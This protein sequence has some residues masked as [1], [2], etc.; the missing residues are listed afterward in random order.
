MAFSGTVSETIFTTRKVIET[1]ARR[2]KVPSAQLT[3]ESVQ[4]AS[5]LLYL[6]ISSYANDG[7]PLW[8]IEKQLY[9]LYEGVARIVMDRGTVDVLNGNTRRIQKLA[10]VPFPSPEVY[11]MDFGTFTTVTTAGLKWLGPAVPVTFERSDTGNDWDWQEAL[12]VTPVAGEGEWTWFDM[13]TF[14]AFNRFR[15]RSTDGTTP[16]PLDRVVFGNTPTEIPLA[17]M[18]KDDYTSLPNKAFKSDQPLQYWFDRQIK[19]PV[20]HLWPVPNAASEEKQV[21]VWRQRHIMDVGAM[22]QE[23]EFPQRW[24]EAVVAGLAAKLVVELPEADLGRKEMLDM[25]ASKTLIA[26]RTEERDNSPIYM[27]PNISPYTR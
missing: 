14:L 15:V 5:D 11:E 10:G 6:L 4:I 23:L 1:A 20:M 9:P 18:N 16:L 24:Y 19:D 3:A 7:A 8:C 12:A 21:V 25:E 26:A 13:P 22:T 2:A 27:A 17:R